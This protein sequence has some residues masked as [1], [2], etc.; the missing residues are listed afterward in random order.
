MI[1]GCTPYTECTESKVKDYTL[2]CRDGKAG[3]TQIYKMD[4]GDIFIGD[5][6]FTKNGNLCNT[7]YK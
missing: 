4:N 2:E 6:Y 3:C 1:A 5:Y 7:K